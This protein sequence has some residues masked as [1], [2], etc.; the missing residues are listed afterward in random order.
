MNNDLLSSSDA[1]ALVRVYDLV[2]DYT[3]QQINF[4]YNQMFW[5]GGCKCY[6]GDDYIDLDNTDDLD[7]RKRSIIRVLTLA[8]DSFLWDK[9]NDQSLVPPKSMRKSLMPRVNS[10]GA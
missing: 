4:V 8:D 7:D 1:K 9:I 6:A 2:A 10:S 5:S 3:T